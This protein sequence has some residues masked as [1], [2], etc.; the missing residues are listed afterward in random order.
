[1]NHWQNIDQTIIKLN[2]T[3]GTKATAVTCLDISKTLMGA[4][5]EFRFH[6]IILLSS[7]PLINRCVF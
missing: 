5:V 6:N 3:S 1:M 4:D 7:P 2:G